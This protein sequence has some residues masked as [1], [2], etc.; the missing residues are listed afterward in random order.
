L[1][2]KSL[3]KAQSHLPSSC[4]VIRACSSGSNWAGHARFSSPAEVTDRNGLYVRSKSFFRFLPC[5][6]KS[7]TS[8]FKPLSPK[9]TQP[10]TLLP[11]ANI[12]LPGCNGRNWKRLAFLVDRIITWHYT[13][14]SS[15]ATIC[16]A[17]C[18]M[19]RGY[20]TPREN[21]EELNELDS[22]PMLAR[23]T[24]R[25]TLLETMCYRLEATRNRTYTVCTLKYRKRF[26]ACRLSSARPPHLAAT[27]SL[28]QDPLWNRCDADRAHPSSPLDHLG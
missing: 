28:H 19:S 4:M 14:E 22:R 25:M 23:S 27:Q 24:P 8:Y 2:C 13:R 9:R 3:Q 11:E 20:F 15:R 12:A 17:M 7:E 5:Y 26:L 10:E 6:E 21:N 18:E 16:G 1:S